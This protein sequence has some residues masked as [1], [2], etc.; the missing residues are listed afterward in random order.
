MRSTASCSNEAPHPQHCSTGCST[1]QS[2]SSRHSN[3][4]PG[5]SAC[6]PLRRSLFV[7][8]LPVR[9]PNPSPDGGLLLLRLF[10]LN[11]FSKTSTRSSSNSNS[12]IRFSNPSTNAITASSPCA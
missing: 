12:S 2:T 4:V 10:L 9:L 5:C 1:T 8:K 7:R 3:V 11:W 6:P